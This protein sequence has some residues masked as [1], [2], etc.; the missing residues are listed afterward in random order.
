MTVESPHVEDL[1]YYWTGD[2]I[3]YEPCLG[4]SFRPPRRD[5]VGAFLSLIAI[6][7]AA[8]VPTLLGVLAEAVP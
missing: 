3:G 1:G 2:R 6:G 8:D 4:P 5:R 7:R